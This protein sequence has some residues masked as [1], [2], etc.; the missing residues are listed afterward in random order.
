MSNSWRPHRLQHARP[1]CPSPTPRVYSDSYPLSWWCHPTMSSSVVP[2]SSHLQSLPTSGS[3]F[4]NESVLHIRWPEDWSFSFSISPS[5]EYSGLISSRM[6][7]RSRPAGWTNSPLEIKPQLDFWVTWP[8][9]H[10][11]TSVCLGCPVF[12][13]W[14]RVSTFR[15][16]S[17]A[18]CLATQSCPTLVTPEIVARQA[19]L[20]MGFSRQEH[21]SGLPF[22]PPGDLADPGT[23]PASPALAGG[24]FTAEPLGKPMTALWPHPIP[25]FLLGSKVVLQNSMDIFRLSYIKDSIAGPTT[26]PKDKVLKFSAFH[27]TYTHSVWN[28]VAD[29]VSLGDILPAGLQF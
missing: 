9:A 12:K 19:P 8:L 21:W 22:P 18:V 4:S 28:T 13:A 15:T 17:C 27:Q 25:A 20:S 2:F 29:T 3:E 16:E 23:K 1:P 6:D 11:F 7:W 26:W 14:I 24:F 5:N 10:F